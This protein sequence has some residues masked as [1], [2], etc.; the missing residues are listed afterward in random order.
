MK[1]YLVGLVLAATTL[2]GQNTSAE[3]A[4]GWT[5]IFDGQSLTG[6]TQQGSAQWTVVDGAIV[7]D[8]GEYGWLRYDKPLTDFE[9]KLEFRTAADGNSGVFVRS[10][11]E[12]APHLTGYEVQIFDKHEKFPT[13]SI[14]GHAAASAPGTI[15]A[16]EWQTMEI[17]AIGPRM[18]VK[19]DGTTLV[20]AR[21]GKSKSGYIG[22]QYNKGKKIEFRN[23]R[24]RPVSR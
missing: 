24:I 18:V 13:G 7:G 9:L 19:L 5:S 16:G 6:W 20:D 22:L 2:F 17:A 21:D 4:E 15:K 10:S 14:V 11:A 1:R 23:V 12:G 3:T 8:A